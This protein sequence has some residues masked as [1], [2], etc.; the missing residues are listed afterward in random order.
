M[1]V[2]DLQAFGFGR[3]ASDI[4]QADG[5]GLPPF[6]AIKTRA[7]RPRSKPELVASPLALREIVPS[8]MTGLVIDTT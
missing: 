6:P 7:Q 2:E 3:D 4:E 8:G 1:T 5:G